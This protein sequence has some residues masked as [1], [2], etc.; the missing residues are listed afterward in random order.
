[1]FF[2]KLKKQNEK[3]Y[4]VKSFGSIYMGENVPDGCFSAME[5]LTGDK[6]PLM[7]V[8]EKRAVYQSS[9][10]LSFDGEKITA[11]LDTPSG[12]LICTETAV[13]LNGEKI[14][15]ASLIA[16][17]K[18]RSAVLFGR[19]IF[20]CPDSICI[21]CTDDGVSVSK[22]NFVHMLMRAQMKLSDEQG[23][24]I[25]PDFFG[26]VPDSAAMGNT[27]V[28]SDGTGMRLYMYS[29]DKWVKSN[30]VFIKLEASSA[31]P[32]FAPGQSVKIESNGGCIDDGY[33]TVKST[34]ENALVLSGILRKTGTVTDVQL[35]KFIPYM[36]F[37]VEHNN[38]IWGCRYGISHEGEFVNEIYASKLGS[39]EEWYCFNGISTDSYAVSLG[40]SGEFTGAAK[41]GNEVIFFK[42]NYLVRVIGDTPSDFTVSTI[43]GRGV[44]K[45]QYK[46]IVNLGERLFYKG[47][48]GIT[49][50]DGNLPFV[51]SERNAFAGYYDSAAGAH[52]GK[53]HIALTSPAGE[54]ARYIYDTE[55][56]LWHKEDD[57]FP[58]AFFF[59][60]DGNLFSLG[61][62]EDGNY[63]L[64]GDCFKGITEKNLSLSLLGDDPFIPQAKGNV[65]W[66]CETGKLCRGITSYNK[67]VRAVRFSLSLSEGAYVKISVKPDSSEEFREIFFLN[68]K[69][70]GIFSASVPVVPCKFF[71]LRFEGAGDLILHG[72]EGILSLTGEVT[73]ID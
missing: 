6:F 49:V 27:M 56:L 30:E 45:G 60:K 5:N 37:A 28:L 10:P 39:A 70:D 72:F 51:I 15:G 61:E 17:A 3:T 47:V 1:M 52:K 73:D 66:Y 53:Y 14:E 67:K 65:E 21:K 38:R 8:R 69:T 42:E 57:S 43:P 48:D 23:T 7:S 11:V 54:R 36:D 16:S 46:S 58:T 12:L 41:V 25:T 13:Y 34:P 24:E 22:N 31:I 68:K 29:G 55:N 4:S 50:Y 26:D 20:I 63:I 64:Q 33:Y 32:G 18:N 62:C 71:T 59:T 40:C 44:E 35:I 19:D 2:P 9:K